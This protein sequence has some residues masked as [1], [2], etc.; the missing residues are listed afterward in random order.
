MIHWIYEVHCRRNSSVAIFFPLASTVSRSRFPFKIRHSVFEIRYSPL[1]IRPPP[2]DGRNFECRTRNVGHGTSNEVAYP[3]PRKK[4]PVA[5]DRFVYDY[6]RR[7]WEHECDQRAPAV[8]SVT[9]GVRSSR[10][11]FDSAFAVRYSTS[12]KITRYT[13]WQCAKI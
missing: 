6:Q 8:R 10:A 5:L 9:N 7:D 13:S 12:T 3:F 4:R 2:L 1:P 11:G